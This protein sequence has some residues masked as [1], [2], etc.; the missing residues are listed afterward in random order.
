[1]KSE[2]VGKLDRNAHIFLEVDLR[3]LVWRPY[4]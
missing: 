3:R 1:M 2:D 4:W